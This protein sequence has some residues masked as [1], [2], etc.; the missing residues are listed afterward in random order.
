MTMTLKNGMFLKTWTKN[1]IQIMSRESSAWI[2]WQTSWADKP[3]FPRLS[4]GY[5]A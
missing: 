3:F 2:G 5:L 1:P 4:T